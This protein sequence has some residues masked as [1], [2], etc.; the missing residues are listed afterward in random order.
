MLTE[1]LDQ[2]GKARFWLDAAILTAVIRVVW[3]VMQKAT[4][5]FL[6][7]LALR[8]K[9]IEVKLTSDQER[10]HGRLRN[11]VHR[12]LGS[13]FKM[14]VDVDGDAAPV[15]AYLKSH[16]GISAVDRNNRPGG[17]QRIFFL[18]NEHPVVETVDGFK[19]NM[20]FPV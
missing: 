11:K 3:T 15:V 5:R 7:A 8:T 2:I 18:L 1:I 17:K 13:Q 12:R 20:I 19:N 4:E 10:H 14:F 16:K 6:F 9:T